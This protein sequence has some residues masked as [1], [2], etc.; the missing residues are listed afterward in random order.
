MPATRA[1]PRSRG[2]NGQPIVDLIITVGSSPLTRGKLEGGDH[3]RPIRGLIPAHAGKTDETMRSISC[4]RAHPRSRGENP[5]Q[6]TMSL[7]RP[8]SSPLTR[9]KHYGADRRRARSRLIPAHAGK[10][11]M[12]T[13]S[14]SPSRAHPRSRGENLAPNPASHT[15]A[16]LI[17]AH[18]GKTSNA[19]AMSIPLGAHPRSRGENGRGA[20]LVQA[21]RGSSPLTRGKHV[22]CACAVLA[23][24]LIP[25]HAG[26]T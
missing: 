1:H 5:R 23:H 9:G 18:A 14:I 12:R 26:K 13:S 3:L 19:D 16:W 17:P 4:L 21:W 20:P 10:T 24:G 15:R 25:A 22:H 2:E 8:G 11:R 6:R 7:P